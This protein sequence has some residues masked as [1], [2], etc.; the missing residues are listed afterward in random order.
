MITEE[1]LNDLYKLDPTMKEYEAELRK[2]ITQLIAAR[3]NTKFDEAFKNKLEQELLQKFKQITSQPI[4]KYSAWDKLAMS[5]FI[6]VM[7]GSLAVV[8]L[9]V[10]GI[11]VVNK[12]P[13]KNNDNK[14]IKLSLKQTIDQT[15]AQAFGALPSF[16]VSHDQKSSPSLNTASKKAINTSAQGGGAEPASFMATADMAVNNSGAKAERALAVGVASKA[17]EPA[18]FIYPPN[19][20]VTVNYTYTGDEF[21]LDNKNLAVYKRNFSGDLANQL[22]RIIGNIDT[23]LLNLKSF[24]NLKA[25]N[26]AL[27]EDYDGGYSFNFD[28]NNESVSLYRSYSP[29][30]VSSDCADK[31]GCVPD[32]YI[33]KNEMPS[34]EEILAVANNFLKNHGVDLSY[35]GKPEINN[36]WTTYEE[37]KKNDYA[38]ANV[39]VVYPQKINEEL[40]YTDNGSLLGMTVNINLKERKI[41]SVYNLASQNFVSSNY[42]AITDWNKILQFALKGGLRPTIYYITA[43][44]GSEK[45]INLE[46]GTPV[47]GLVDR[48][49]YDKTSQELFVPAL[50]FPIKNK[51][52][53]PGY[54]NLNNVIVPLIEEM[55][56][57]ENDNYGGGV[58]PMRSAEGNSSGMVTQSA[59]PAITPSKK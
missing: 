46:L 30:A 12:L 56:P 36:D 33:S 18:S 31:T 51:T 24:S 45:Q 19:P 42:P 17:V 40:T 59:R 20:Q 26:L 57:K 3:P 50:I 43:E 2:L 32:Y 54:G 27:Q 34:N 49:I 25:S 4:K 11:M 37:F 55:F 23:G 13:Q 16:Q 44:N 41:D 47:Y 9:F 35:W 39:S 8:V 6:Y 48:W 58:Y 21:K 53:V 14:L 28:F 1:I 10:A 22:G 29:Q 15:S 52:M 5:K 7:G 38:P